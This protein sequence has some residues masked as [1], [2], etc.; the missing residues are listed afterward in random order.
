M[1]FNCLVWI[2]IG[3]QG[4]ELLWCQ[5][6]SGSNSREEEKSSGRTRNTTTGGKRRR[7]P[8]SPL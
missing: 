2:W 7:L 8:Q 3:W 5:H 6:A 1:G 4:E